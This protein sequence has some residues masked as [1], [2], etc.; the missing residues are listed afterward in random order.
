MKV[1]RLSDCVGCLSLY[2]LVISCFHSA[3]SF[4]G[5]TGKHNDAA[6]SFPAS[7]LGQGN[8]TFMVFVLHDKH[9]L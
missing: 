2:K 5:T 8:T 3:P 4:A 6:H 7:V 1:C 9:S